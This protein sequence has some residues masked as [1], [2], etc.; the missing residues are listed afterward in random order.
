MDEPFQRIAIDLIGPIA[1][2]TE[3][4]HRYILTIVDFATRY[5]EAIPLKSVETERVAEALLSVF[6]RVGFP[7]EVLSDRGSQFTSELMKEICRL[8]SMKQVFTTPYNPRCNGLVERMNAVLKSM[9][10]KM[11]QER[12]QDWDRYLPAVLFAYREVPQAST[13]FAPFELLYGRTVRGPM[14]LLK[15]LWTKE[16]HS[17][18]RNTYQYVVDLKN[19]M[20]ETCKLARE[21]LESSQS[22]Y[23][24]HYDKK[25]RNRTFKVGTKVL[26]LLPTDHNKLLMEWQGPF[27]VTEIINEMDY[28]VRVRNKVKIYH[29]NLLKEYIER[30]INTAAS[31]CVLDPE[32]QEG[33]Q[34]GVVDNELLLEVCESKGQESYRDIDVNR[35]LTMEQK[36]GIDDIVKTYQA[37]FTAEPGSTTVTTH[38]IETT[39]DIPICVKPY[40][41]PYAT[42]KNI[43]EEVQKML[44][45]G[46]IEPAISP[47]NSPIVLV[48]KKDDSIRFCI[49]FRKL[50]SVTKFDTHPMGNMEDILT[51]VAKDK[52]FTKIDLA[53]GYWQ[54][55]VEEESKP[56]T[57]FVTH[58]G[59]YQFTKM[60]FGLVNSGSTFNRMMGTLLQ[61]LKHVDH[62]VDDILIHTRTWEEHIH[63]LAAVIQR[64]QEAGLTVRP[65]KCKIG[66]SEMEFTGQIIGGGTVSTETDKVNQIKSATRPRT[67][68]QVRSFL[69]LVGFYRKYI[70]NF[71]KLSTPLT[72][73]TKK[74]EPN[75]VIWTEIQER[76]FQ[77]LK[78]KLTTSPILRLP[79]FTREFIIQTDA[80]DAAIGAV[81]LQQF[82]DGVFPIALLM[83]KN[84]PNDW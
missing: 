48:K 66:Y 34:K 81:L 9:L 15:E 70:P 64:I 21:N 52:F 31:A 33:G 68:K 58:S 79:D 73:L 25:T 28:K 75:V 3:Q 38:R 35:A 36:K 7:K 59:A 57:A 22:I 14:H 61:D 53:K 65:S 10:R 63:T 82:H 41:M 80:S 1:P 16:S 45:I 77:S 6:C 47:Y 51:K 17:E 39:T 18:V 54:I 44:D 24:H 26:L 46:V 40:P 32:R 50:N 78:N 37:V 67:K 4:G 5:P 12:P 23:K 55:P 20:A 69:G 30:K 83:E 60:P 84:F 8:I 43:E 19:R 72:D 29:A 62:Y 13:G 2:I 56:K 27:E 11:C 76:A 49:D 74:G 71:A 42:R